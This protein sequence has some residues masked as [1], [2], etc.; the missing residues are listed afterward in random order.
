MDQSDAALCQST[1][2]QHFNPVVLDHGIAEDI[3]RDGVE[4]V[5][6]GFMVISKYLP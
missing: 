3:A 1:L 6:R 2:L 4:I 5:A